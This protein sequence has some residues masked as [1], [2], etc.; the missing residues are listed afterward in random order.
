METVILDDSIKLLYTTAS[1]FP[2][3]VLAAH[4]TLH[5]LIPYQEQRQYFGLSR[6]ERGRGIVYKA[7]AKEMHPGEAEE[8]GLDTLLL[9]EGKY[10]SVTVNNFMTD[11]S[12]VGRTF[13]ELLKQPGIDPDGYCVEIY[14]NSHD[15]KCMV[16]LADG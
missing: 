15:V 3:G 11:L 13:G 16:R 2:E 4:Q 5:A 7:A 8:L 6:P 10:L 9:K 12:S 14:P 1:S